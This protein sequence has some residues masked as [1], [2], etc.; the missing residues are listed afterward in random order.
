MTDFTLDTPDKVTELHFEGVD[1]CFYVWVNGDLVG[2]S[3]VSHSTSAFDIS[4]FVHAGRNRLAVLVMKW[5]DGSYLEDQ[6]KLRMSG[7]FRDVYLMH[8]PQHHIFDYTVRTPV[9]DDL[10]EAAIELSVVWNDAPGQAMCTL[11]APD[12]TQLAQQPPDTSGNVHFALDH[13]VLWNAEHPALYELVICADGE[14]IV[15]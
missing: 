13:P 15:Q 6:D 5:C 1:S 10:R 11:Y 3:Q 9:S 14:T 12:G 4:A 8:R 7:I 2:Y